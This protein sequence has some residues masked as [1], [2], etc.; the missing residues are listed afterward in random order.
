MWILPP[1]KTTP[2]TG[3]AMHRS[4]FPFTHHQITLQVFAQPTRRIDQQKERWVD[5]DSINS[6]PIPSPHH[7]AITDLL[8]ARN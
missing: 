5:L 6:I 7:R 1:L 4:V 2:A 8:G 3:R